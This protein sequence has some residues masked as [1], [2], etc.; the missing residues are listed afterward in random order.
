MCLYMPIQWTVAS[1]W[2][3]SVKRPTIGLTLLDDQKS[4]LTLLRL[5]TTNFECYFLA[6]SGAL[7]LTCLLHK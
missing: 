2:K 6:P 3:L 4:Q 1:I 5:P 7:S